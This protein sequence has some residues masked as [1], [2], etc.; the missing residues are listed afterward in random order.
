MEN[1]EWMEIILTVLIIIGIALLCYLGTKI[2]DKISDIKQKKLKQ[3]YS[4]I[5]SLFDDFIDKRQQYV[6]QEWDIT[7]VLIQ[8]D[9]DLRTKMVMA[10]PEEKEMYENNI[11]ENKKR[12]RKEKTKSAKY[13]AIQLKAYYKL[14]NTISA[15]SEKKDRQALEYMY[16]TDVDFFEKEE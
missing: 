5:V 4:Y 1:T 10:L 9:K 2:Y 7:K 11:R 16:I 6:N 13:K 12:I 8:K 3:K 14:K 15:V